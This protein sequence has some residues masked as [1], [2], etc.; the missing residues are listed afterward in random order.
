MVFFFNLPHSLLIELM[1]PNKTC[2]LKYLDAEDKEPDRYAHVVLDNRATEHPYYQDLLVG[3]LPVDNHTTKITP[4]NYSYNKNSNGKVRN[5]AADSKKMYTEWIYPIADSIKDITIDLFGG[6]A[7]GAKNDTIDIFE[8]DPLWQDDGRI[9]R[10]DAF[11]NLPTTDM[12]TETLLPL[13]LY[14]RSDVTGRDPSKWKFEGWLYDDIFYPTT[15]EF[16]KAYWSKG[17]QKLVANA[18]GDWARSDQQGRVPP[19]DTLFSPTTS[20]PGGSR[21]SVD[22]KEKYIKW[23]DFEFYLS[24]NRDTGMKLF[25]IK[26]KGER[27]IY[28]LGLQEAIA[29]YAGNDPLQSGTSYLDSYYG[30][31]KFQVALKRLMHN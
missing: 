11:W 16:K 10:W 22:D 17:F 25:D 2:A 27:I 5:L 1:T 6:V 28:E 18:E 13:G 23:M 3:P 31:G 7:S 20:L 12:D 24:F 9:T 15:Q 26:Y 30:F 8:I 19:M 29:H 4:L 14:F 21:Y